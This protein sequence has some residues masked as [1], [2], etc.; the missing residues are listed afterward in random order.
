MGGPA[1][2]TEETEISKHL[3]GPSKSAVNAMMQAAS[4]NP[5]AKEYTGPR[6]AAVNPAQKQAMDLAATRGNSLGF[7]FT[8]ASQALPEST[9][10]GGMEVY[11]TLGLAQNNIPP[12]LQAL[13]SDLFGANG[14][15]GKY[16]SGGSNE[17]ARGM[18][19]PFGRNLIAHSRDMGRDP[20]TGEIVPLPGGTTR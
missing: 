2:T 14:I 17:P 5:W 18:G 7:D 9:T 12:A 16:R 6:M 15:L 10:I 4:V 8:P 20:V 3:R 19:S 13:Y 1:E 11:D